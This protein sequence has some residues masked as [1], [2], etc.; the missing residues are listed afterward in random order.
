MRS[1]NLTLLSV[2]TAVLPAVGF[3]LAAPDC[4]HASINM[5]GSDDSSHSSFNAG[6][7]WVG[8]AVPSA[9]N[10]YDTLG[11]QL[12]TP[13]GGT[14]NYIFAGSSLTVSFWRLI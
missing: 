10:A 13:I 5:K 8:G 2:A 7:N 3:L 1:K 9:G 12:R 4:V 6:T 14:G 11:Y